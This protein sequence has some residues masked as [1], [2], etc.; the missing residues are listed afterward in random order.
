MHRHRAAYGH[1]GGLREGV[2]I[3]AK[4]TRW[5]AGC[6]RLTR[7]TRRPRTNASGAEVA[8]EVPHEWHR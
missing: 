1:V 2:L 7:R 8:W 4:G 6:S 3:A 5:T